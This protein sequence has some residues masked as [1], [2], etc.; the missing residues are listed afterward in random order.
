M[1]VK[2]AGFPCVA[3]MGSSLSEQQEEMLC[4]EFGRVIL[5]FDGDDAGMVATEDSA[6]RLVRRVFVKAVH[7]LDGQQPD[8]LTAVQI[9]TLLK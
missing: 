5:M 8:M 9:A 2:Q 7:L 3:L 1:K 6:R 4:L